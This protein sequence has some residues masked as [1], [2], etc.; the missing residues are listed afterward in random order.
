MATTTGAVST[1]SINGNSFYEFT[2]SGTITYASSRTVPVLI[3]GGGGG[4]GAGQVNYEG[5]GGGG[6]GGVGYGSL[7]FAAGTTYTITVGTGGTGASYPVPLFESTNGTS[8][9]NSSIVGGSINAVA[10]GGGRGGSTRGGTSTAEAGGSSGG[11]PGW[12][13]AVQNNT[14]GTG[15]G[16]TY[17]GNNGGTGAVG[18]SGGGGGGA[19]SVGASGKNGNGGAGTKSAGGSGYTWPYTNNTYG[20][21]GGGGLA[22]D[23]PG[24][25]TTPTAYGGNG[26][27][28][29]GGTGGGTSAP[30]AGT[31]KT[32]GGGGGAC[33]RPG[34][35]N[36]ANGGRGV[37]YIQIVGT[38]GSAPTI[39]SITTDNLSSISVFFTPGTGGSPDPTT[40]YYSLDGGITYTNANSTTS[41][42]IISGLIRDSPYNIALIATNIAGNTAAS[43]IVPI[44]ITYPCFKQGTR[45]LAFIKGRE[46]YVP[47]ETLKRSD[48]VKTSKSGYKS[49]SL[50]GKKTIHNSPDSNIKNRLFRYSQHICPELIEDL[51]ITGEHCAL[52][53]VVSDEKLQEIKDHMGKIYTTEGDYRVPA[54]LDSRAKPYEKEGLYT[55]WHF[56]LENE[57]PH[58]NY[59]VY[60][61][62]LLVESASEEYLQDYSN[63][64]LV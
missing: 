15:S 31:N 42:I 3:V 23:Y 12:G 7:T 29:G 41:P 36:A 49:I 59:G 38:V 10:Y 39:T 61:N 64:E 35:G 56:A 57:S 14:K 54:H 58:A 22:G 1:V 53:N 9:S 8:G 18:G 55:I 47:V 4:G 13:S 48:L 52:V 6:G 46:Q 2:G 33:S 26:G 5:P 40:Y 28:G 37:V 32:G 51:C 24:F 44:T 27:T 62:G 60:A 25:N 17:L 21:G 20:G 63:M 19:G 45:I 34:V 30:T 50:I 16:L 43:N 11:S